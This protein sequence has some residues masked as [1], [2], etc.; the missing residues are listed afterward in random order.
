MLSLPLTWV[1]QRLA[2]TG[3]TT[4]F[5][6]HRFNQQLAASQLSVS[7]SIAGLRL[8]SETNWADFAEAMSLVEQTLRQDPSGIYPAMHFDTRDHYR[9]IIEILAR[10]SHYS[11]PEVAHH[12]LEMAKL[13]DPATPSHHVG[14]YLIG[15]GRPQ[16][17][18]QLAANTSPIR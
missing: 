6:I 10:H 17:E 11:E 3:V 2:E 18:Q 14:Y 16:L 1:E 12:I 5:L 9:H 13:T 7:N 4:E 15:E 8:L